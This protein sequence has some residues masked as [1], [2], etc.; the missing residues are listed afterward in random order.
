MNSSS[1]NSTPAWQVERAQRLQRACRSIETRLARGEQNRRAFRRVAKYQHGRPFRC[2]PSRTM[3]LSE[4]TLRYLFPRWKNGGKVSAAFQLHYRPRIS[5]IPAP[6]LVCFAEFCANNRLRSL[7]S[8]W[9]QFS[10]SVRIAGKPLQFTYYQVRYEFTAANFYLLQHHVAA[11][12]TAQTV[13]AKQRLD[14]IS[15][16]RSRLPDRRP[17][18]RVKREIAPQI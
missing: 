18:Q 14:I 10:K 2:D 7:A 9:A 13:L 17:R 11:L 3:R 5:A 1:Q 6:V 15:K 16:I 12:R 4:G 8:A